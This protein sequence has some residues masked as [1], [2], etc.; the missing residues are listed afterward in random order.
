MVR[1]FS[2]STLKGD[3]KKQRMSFFKL[4]WQVIF[5]S[6]FENIFMY[7]WS[8]KK[9]APIK[10]HYNCLVVWRMRN[11]TV[12]N[13]GHV[14]MTS[15]INRSNKRDKR[16]ASTSLSPSKSCG[17]ASTCQNQ[18]KLTSKFWLLAGGTPAARELGKWSFF[19]KASQPS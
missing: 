3:G 5:N 19:F 9:E 18:I 1:L 4:Y 13:G 6:V 14:S 8:S 10:N 15:L 7:L 2:F 11:G 16:L 17:S 12:R